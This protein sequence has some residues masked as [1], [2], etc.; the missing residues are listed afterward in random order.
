MLG[1]GPSRL[2]RGGIRSR[3][4]QHDAQPGGL[5]TTGNHTGISSEGGGPQRLLAAETSCCAR[6]GGRCGIV[7][8]APMLPVS[9]ERVDRP[10]LHASLRHEALSGLRAA[11][12]SSAGEYCAR[13]LLPHPPS[14]RIAP[15]ARRSS[16]QPSG[17]SFVSATNPDEG[18]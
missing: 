3:S 15:L 5:R 17:E 7:P 14:R 9:G 4:N 2:R 6:S 11:A 16:R 12:A 8:P 1:Q 10:R 13:Q 18:E